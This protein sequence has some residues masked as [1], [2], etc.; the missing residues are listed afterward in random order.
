MSSVA[1]SAIG[2]YPFGKPRTPARGSCSSNSSGREVEAD[3]AF[4]FC[5]EALA[6]GIDA[7]GNCG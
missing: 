4:L 1:L 2:S 6:A 5:S 3:E 7:L